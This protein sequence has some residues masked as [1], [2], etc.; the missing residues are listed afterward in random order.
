M[1]HRSGR[2]IDLSA[3]SAEDERILRAIHGLGHTPPGELRCQAHATNVYLVMRRR[4]ET[5][6]A[7]HWPGTAADSRGH[8]IALMTPEHRAQVEY[9][10]R[11]ADHAGLPVATEVTLPTRVRP[12][13]VVAGDTGFEAQRS[14]ITVASIKSRTT[15]AIRGGLRTTTWISDKEKAPP[16]MGAVPA[17]RVFA[18]DWL[19][20]PAPGE[21]KVVGGLV[22]PGRQRCCP[23]F[24]FTCPETRQRYCGQWHITWAPLGGT[25]DEL[26][27]GLACGEF[28]P[29]RIRKFA[30]IAN[31]RE[32]TTFDVPHWTPPAAKARI[33]RSADRVECHASGGM[34]YA[35]AV[36]CGGCLAAVE[37]Q[38]LVPACK[39]CSNSPSY[40]RAA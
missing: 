6:W 24:T 3:P 27:V 10:V 16:W 11:A 39:L 25:L 32:A 40:W 18:R 30:F 9:I 37:G 2:E 21:A 14:G 13:V 23:P 33:L 38:P 28:V 7:Q 34:V 8:A 5:M 31:A 36:C 26:T 12:D 35:D 17:V 22:R 15:K 19:R 20:L 29:V 1:V 4:D